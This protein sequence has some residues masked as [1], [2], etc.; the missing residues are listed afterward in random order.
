MISHLV[1]LYDPHTDERH[2][3][4]TCD[5]RV[6]IGAYRVRLENPRQP[7][8]P[9][10]RWGTENASSRT[11]CSGNSGVKLLGVSREVCVDANATPRPPPADD[12]RENT[13]G[14]H[15]QNL[16]ILTQPDTGHVGTARAISDL[17][18][19]SDAQ[20]PIQAPDRAERQ[21]T[22]KHSRR[23]LS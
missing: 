6:H 4:T 20:Q 8:R 2:R 22:N 13:P 7:S 19:P 11:A 12:I 9:S 5:H 1:R 10:I 23:L 3:S 16:P 17:G 14:A 15:Y 21:A 18:A